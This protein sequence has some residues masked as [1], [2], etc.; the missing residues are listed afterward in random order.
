MT[1]TTQFTPVPKSNAVTEGRPHPGP[2]RYLNARLA[3]AIRAGKDATGLS[4]RELAV[5]TGISRAHL[6]HLSL[7]RRAPSHQTTEAL[8]AALDLD[9]GVAEELRAASVSTWPHNIKDER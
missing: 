7:G 1:I 4:W 2:Q 9:E 8:I 6:N 5:R 3:H